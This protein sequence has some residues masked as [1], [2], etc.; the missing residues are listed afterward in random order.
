[1][2]TE[3][4][5]QP[6]SEQTA[7]P[8]HERMLGDWQRVIPTGS[9]DLDRA[10]GIG[11]WPRGR[12]VEIYGA[13]AVGKTTLVLEAVAQTQQRSGFATVIDADHG[14]D[15]ASL[16]R[17]G[18]DPGGLV[19]HRTNKIEDVFSTIEDLLHRGADLI[20]LDGIAALLPQDSEKAGHFPNTKNER[21]QSNIEHALKAILGPL[22]SSRAVL[23]VTNQIR[24][25][26]GV[27][28]GDPYMTPWET[29]PL[30]NFASVRLEVKRITHVKNGEDVIGSENR[31][32]VVKNRLAPAFR[33]A[34]FE[35]YN[36]SGICREAELIRLGVEH[37]VMTKS[38]QA[39]RFG[40]VLLGRTELTATRALQRDAALTAQLHEAVL[41][42]LAP[43]VTPPQPEP[44]IAEE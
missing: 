13:E 40:N 21:H 7:L 16:A 35:I 42:R 39:F 14:L 31:V 30:K 26:I 33:N 34:E 20:A 27:M 25:K 15:P 1:M 29:M 3:T 19:I 6:P 10:L 23:L 8:A 44:S 43:T 24:E 37:D 36:D 32:R 28:Y 17:F 9:L 38:G 5:D 18:I 2:S 22:F 4:G 11:G 12:I 41:N